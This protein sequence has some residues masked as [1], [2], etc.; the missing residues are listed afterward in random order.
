MFAISKLRLLR[1]YKTMALEVS[2][3]TWKLKKG[4]LENLMN[5]RQDFQSEPNS[6]RNRLEKQY[7]ALF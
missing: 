6:C 2:E 4:N 1:A 3:A 5:W 7:F